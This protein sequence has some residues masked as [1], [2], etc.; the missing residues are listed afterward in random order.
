MIGCQDCA[1]K[2]P[3][4]AIEIRPSANS[5]RLKASVI[6]ENYKGCGVCIV[7]YEQKAMRYEIVRSPEYMA[8]RE[9]KFPAPA[10]SRS[11]RRIPVNVKISP[12]GSFYKLN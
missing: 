7:G 3:F 6:S 1:K 9:F 2:C 5:K 8:N 12:Y 10:P 4:D 11:G